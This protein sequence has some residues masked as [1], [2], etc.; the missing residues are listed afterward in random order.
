[1]VVTVFRSRLRASVDATELEAVGTRMFEIAS[2]MPGFVS[3]KDFAAED[4]E[5]VSVVEFESLA[6]LEAW[7]EQAEHRVA[8][9]R[10][11]EAFF[12][13]YHIQVCE[14]VRDYAWRCEAP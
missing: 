4:G 12:A 6:T 2:H 10:G 5:F 11:R 1:M 7:R 3:Y 13:E 8:Q 14:T 9:Q